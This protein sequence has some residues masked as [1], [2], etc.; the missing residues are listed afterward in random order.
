M[1]GLDMIQMVAKVQGM[2][3][4]I[5]IA[6]E[7]LGMIQMTPMLQEEGLDWALGLFMTLMI[8][9]QE[10]G[11]DMIPIQEKD[12]DM[13]QMV[14]KFQGMFQM[15]IQPLPEGPKEVAKMTLILTRMT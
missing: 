15:M 12:L 6:A 14:A 4:M 5:Q 10:R 2:F 11:P 7:A 3:Q 9:I 1:G 8:L 13:I